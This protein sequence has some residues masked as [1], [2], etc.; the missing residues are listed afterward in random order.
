MAKKKITFEEGMQEL[1][2]IVRG[3]EQG[4]MPLEESFKA[5]ERAKQL[6]K[7]LQDMLDEGDRRIRVLTESGERTLSEEVGE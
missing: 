3:L 7:V 4:Q 5:F 2:D 6:Q 1:E